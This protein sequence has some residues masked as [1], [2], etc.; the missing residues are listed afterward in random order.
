MSLRITVKNRECCPQCIKHVEII[1]LP[2]P[3]YPLQQLLTATVRQ[4]W[5]SG[6]T[7]HFMESPPPFLVIQPRMGYHDHLR[8][9]LDQNLSP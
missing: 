1:N 3:D 8:G 9:L 7:T 4:V 6:T 2:C 5:V